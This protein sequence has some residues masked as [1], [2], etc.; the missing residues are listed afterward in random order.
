MWGFAPLLAAAVLVGGCAPARTDLITA[1]RVI[2]EPRIDRTLRA[3]PEIYEDRG[4]LVVSGRLGR[5]FPYEQGGHVA[6]TVIDPD[7]R[8]VYDAVVN[9]EAD[10]TAS[11]G[12]PEPRFGTF[13]SVRTRRYASYDVYLI[14]F[15]GLPPDGSIIQV[16]HV[17]SS[18]NPA[19]LRASSAGKPGAR[20]L[21]AAAK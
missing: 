10:T 16:R 20:R 19:R 12:T 14:R 8:I 17:P 7:R 15:P 9:Y 4:D 3:P 6:V 5:G 13:R 2:A 11:S 18:Q 1:G 21:A